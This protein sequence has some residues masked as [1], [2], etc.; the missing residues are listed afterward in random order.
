MKQLLACKSKLNI[1]SGNA[2]L[3]EFLQMVRQRMTEVIRDIVKQMMP[4]R[5]W[6]D[7]SSEWRC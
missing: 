6:R 2:T 1:D 7:G 4:T 5:V 3:T